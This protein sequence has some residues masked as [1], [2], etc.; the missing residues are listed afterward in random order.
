MYLYQEKKYCTFLVFTSYERKKKTALFLLVHCTEVTFSFFSSCTL[1][2]KKV[3]FSVPIMTLVHKC[4][5]LYREKGADGGSE[6][7]L[8]IVGK[9]RQTISW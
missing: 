3:E 5:G 8:R 6:T 2:K 4:F 9:F 1:E 7:R